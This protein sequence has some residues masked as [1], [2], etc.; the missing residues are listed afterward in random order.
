MKI[1][2]IIKIDKK[3]KLLSVTSYGKYRY[4]DLPEPWR[5]AGKWCT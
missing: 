3:L 5:I 2:Y 1:K 4:P